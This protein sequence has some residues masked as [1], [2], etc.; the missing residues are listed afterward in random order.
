MN[1]YKIIFYCFL[2]LL[3]GA[4]G[5]VIFVVDTNLNL[6]PRPV[7]VILL[8]SFTGH[9]ISFMEKVKHGESKTWIK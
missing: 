4:M 7:A 1:Q 3:T 6:A 9:I 5:V 8:I 2:S